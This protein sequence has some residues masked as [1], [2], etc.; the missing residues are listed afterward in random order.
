MTNPVQRL[1]RNIFSNYVAMAAR[2]A[3]G[4]VISPILVHGL[5]KEQYGIWVLVFSLINYLGFLDFGMKQSL[6]RHFPKYYATKDYQ[7]LN[8]VFNSSNLIYSIIGVLTIIGTF[9]IAFFFMGAINVSPD[10]VSVMRILLIMVGLNQ[11]IAFFFMTSTAIGPFHRYDVSNAIEIVRTVANALAII[12]F[13]HLGYGLLTLGVI[14]LATTVTNT[15]ARRFA[16]QKIVP[17]LKY[18]LKF[19]KKERLRELLSYSVFSFLIVLGLLTLFNADNVII[20]A[21]MSTS[22]VTIYSIAATLINYLR[23]L[24]SSIGVP[25]A[26]AV[27]H[28]DASSDTGEIA[29]LVGKLFKYLYYLTTAVCIGFLLFG[30][31]FIFLWMG[32]GFEET[33]RILYLLIIPAGIY[34]PQIMSN[35]VFFGTGKHKTLF[36]IIGAEAVAKIVISVVLVR[37]WGL[38]G[39]ALGT[40]I[41]QVCIYTFIYPYIFHKMIKADLRQFYVD[42]LK[43]SLTSVIF[44]LP[45]GLAINYWFTAESWWGF[46]AEVVVVGVFS[47]AG[48]W[49]RVMDDVDKNRVLKRITRQSARPGA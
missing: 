11:A 34:L 13:V 18:G 48:F 31:D 8:E 3:V 27:S 7:K 32:P 14:T 19:I 1:V 30:D 12:Y 49:W 35:S 37:F 41:P 28:L 22:A 10:L 45:V 38:F 47:M 39:V 6:A 16:Q 23:T 5:G 2:M 20:G 24:V 40:V 36:Y 15:A 29:R 17:Q 26:P 25:L 4:F 9:V 21:F 33:V 42:T 44:A 43:V 46:I